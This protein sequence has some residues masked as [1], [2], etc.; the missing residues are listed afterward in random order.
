MTLRK[1]LPRRANVGQDRS[2][3]LDVKGDSISSLA[4]DHQLTVW[5]NWKSGSGWPSGSSSGSA[6]SSHAG[7]PRAGATGGGYAGSPMYSKM[8]RTE[9]LSVTNAMICMSAPH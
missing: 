5:S 8:R 6:S 1:E 2:V 4:L 3:A 9:T 7:G